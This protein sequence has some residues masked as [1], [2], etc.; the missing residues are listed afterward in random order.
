M[1]YSY[2]ITLAIWVYNYKDVVFADISNT[3]TSIYKIIDLITPIDEWAGITFS[4][5]QNAE[6][7]HTE[8]LKDLVHKL[9]FHH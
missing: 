1:R 4:G 7:E 6:N 8:T 5:R 2:I 9:N 3:G